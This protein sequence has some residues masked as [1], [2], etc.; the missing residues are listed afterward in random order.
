MPNYIIAQI[1][2][3]LIMFIGWIIIVGG[4]FVSIIYIT[5]AKMLAV[6]PAQVGILV[7]RVPEL[8]FYLPV[9]GFVIIGLL[10]VALGH[11]LQTSID[12]SKYSAESVQ[13]LEL[14]RVKGY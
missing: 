3:L 6:L 11:L 10:I 5:K 2:S 12:N 7:S 8:V 13:I 1:I 9:A 4:S 14:M